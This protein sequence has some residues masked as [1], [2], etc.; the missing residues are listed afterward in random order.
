MNDNGLV[1]GGNGLVVPC[2]DF[3]DVPVNGFI[4]GSLNLLLIP[5]FG[6]TGAALA[7]FVSL[8]GGSVLYV[9][10]LV[11]YLFFKVDYGWFGR[12]YGVALL[13]FVL[14]AAGAKIADATLLGVL[15]VLGFAII[16]YSLLLSGEDRTLLKG[17]IRSFVQN[18]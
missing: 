7:T 13:G 18:R 15:I 6:I 11:K 2:C 4:N 9:W 12:I 10:L 14:Y 5:Q 8:V 17:L 16:I 1:V 3:N